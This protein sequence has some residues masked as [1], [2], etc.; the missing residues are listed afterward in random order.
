MK[1]VSEWFAAL[2]TIRKF[3]IKANIG[4]FRFTDGERLI[5]EAL[6]IMKKEHY[7]P[8]CGYTFRFCILY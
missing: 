5:D 7:C 6:D 3:N 2:Q 1:D 4:G 8:N